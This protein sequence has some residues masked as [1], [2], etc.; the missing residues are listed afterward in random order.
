[1]GGRWPSES[2]QMIFV[3]YALFVLFPPHLFPVFNIWGN[4]IKI[5]ISGITGIAYFIVKNEEC[6]FVFNLQSC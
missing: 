2:L 5:Q 1:M 3:I 6:F 4:N